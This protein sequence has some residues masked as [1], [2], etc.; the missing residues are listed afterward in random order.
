MTTA[1]ES[2][3]PDLCHRRFPFHC[4]TALVL[5]KKLGVD[6]TQVNMRAVGCY[7][8]YK[9]EVLEQSPAPG[10]PLTS[11]VSIS[12]DIGQWSAV[13]ILPYQFFYGMTGITN[14]TGGW[15]DDARALMAPFDAAIVRG[16]ANADFEML[17]YALSTIDYQHL[18]RFLG[19]FDID[20][21]R[22]MADRR[23]ANFW[24]A[25]MPTHHLWAGNP[26]LI[27]RILQ[28][29][30]GHKFSIH[31]NMPSSQNIPPAIRSRLGTKY[32][33]LSS[34]L[35]LGKSFT[36]YDSTYNIICETRS[37][38]I[39]NWLP[40]K[41]KRKKL[42]RILNMCMPGN[43]EYWIRIR[44]KRDPLVLGAT[45]GKAYLGY[46]TFISGHDVRAYRQQA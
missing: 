28:H 37:D 13:D 5:L 39:K 10:T 24:A 12:L 31:E 40:G 14:R 23:E 3:M 46:G 7:E 26:V 21:R 44:V 15:E 41:K 42:E 16:K 11:G 20:H 2:V 29:M 6:V 18:K 4:V 19:L 30:F 33:R 43:L 27:S 32:S 34:E 25:L 35:V 38:D 17:K 1:N 22:D 36:E 45:S 9:G 8:N